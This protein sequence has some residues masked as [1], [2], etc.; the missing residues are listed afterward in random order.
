MPGRNCPHSQ[1]CLEPDASIEILCEALLNSSSQEL[2]HM[3]NNLKK[4]LKYL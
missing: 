3:Q 1:F 2:C 4:E